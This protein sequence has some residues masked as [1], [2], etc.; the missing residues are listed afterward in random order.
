MRTGQ[1][2]ATTGGII[3]SLGQ[4][5]PGGEVTRIRGWSEAPHTAL[6]G[7]CIGNTRPVVDAERVREAMGDGTLW[8][9]SEQMGLLPF[10]G[11]AA[12]SE[13]MILRHAVRRSTE[14]SWGGCAGRAALFSGCAAGV[15]AA[16]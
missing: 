12:V 16:G 2:R 6:V 4:A 13:P 15:L 5:S 9:T 14:Q 3:L 7:V 11:V 10:R 1:D 8:K